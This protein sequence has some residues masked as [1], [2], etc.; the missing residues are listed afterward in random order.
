TQ[1]V[2]Y[3]GGDAGNT[4]ASA[5]IA[6]FNG[7]A[8]TT[9]VGKRNANGDIVGGAS[10]TSPHADS[11]DLEFD[12]SGNLMESDDGGLYRLT[13]PNN[14]GPFSWQSAN[15]NL[16]AIEVAAVAY[17]SLNN[18]LVIG[19]QDNGGAVKGTDEGIEWRG[20]GAGD[21]N[22]MQVVAGPTF[23]THYLMQNNFK[24]FKR[25]TVDE[26]NRLVDQSAPNW[27]ST[28]ITLS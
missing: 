27:N 12:A 16:R 9:V 22:T 15:G 3:A 7:S 5:H 1:G 20:F 28:P 4:T 8:W 6:K 10:G 18:L 25:R 14:P 13:N 24:F 11:R 17:D 23:S 26:H 2:F 21:G 19:N